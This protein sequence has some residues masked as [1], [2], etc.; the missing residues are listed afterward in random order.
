MY[1]HDSITDLEK[2]G[3]TPTE[4]AFLYLAGRNSGYFVRR[5]FNQFAR[6]S[7][8]ARAQ[9]FVDKALAKRHAEALDY[10]QRR[11]IYHLSSRTIYGV[12]QIENSPARHAKGDHEIATR[13]LILDYL[14]AHLT[15]HWLSTEI[16][17]V[18]F[19]CNELAI[20]KHQLP[21]CLVR[22]GAKTVTRSFLDRF[23]IAILHS[24]KNGS[25]SVRFTYFDEGART[26]KA[27]AR[28]L[29]NHQN[30]FERLNSFELAFVSLSSR[31]LL[32]AEQYFQRLFPGSS[33]LATRLL[34]EGVDHI[35]RFFEAERRLD[36]KDPHFSQTD[37]ATLRDGEA[38]Y[39]TTKHD[40]LRSAWNKSR[41]QFEN[42][43]RSLGEAIVPSAQFTKHLVEESYPVF[44]YR[45]TAGW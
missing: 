11:Y 29:R 39:S 14:L 22:N 23:P 21:R 17:K 30:L 16:E 19:F 10:G 26:I 4:A 2:L 31:N 5:Q 3:Y 7:L 13:L 8:G 27:F 38:I 36:R 9:R 25:I 18:N 35:I 1:Q 43:L 42:Q 28:F 20:E 33:A 40:L 15:E 34:P 41:L 24:P 37:L 12:L 45:K 32:A 44:G 6:G